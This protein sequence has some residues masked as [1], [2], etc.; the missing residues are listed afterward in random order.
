[1]NFKVTFL[2]ESKL[3][4]ELSS[5]KD[6]PKYSQIQVKSRFFFENVPIYESHYKMA[7]F[8]LIDKA[9]QTIDV[10]ELLVLFMRKLILLGS[11]I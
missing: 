9:L 2:R 8:P 4:A 6:F 3:S 7:C 5:Q 1:L 10:Y 11:L